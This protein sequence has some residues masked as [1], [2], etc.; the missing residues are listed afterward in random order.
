MPLDAGILV[1]TSGMPVFVYNLQP[2][3]NCVYPSD[4]SCKKKLGKERQAILQVWSI[5]AAYELAPGF[6]GSECLAD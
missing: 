4:F 6:G 1:T 3:N 2:D 5:N